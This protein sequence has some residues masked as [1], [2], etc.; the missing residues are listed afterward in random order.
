MYQTIRTEAALI[1]LI[2]QIFECKIQIP[3]KQKIKSIQLASS[4]SQDSQTKNKA[5]TR[6][7]AQFVEEAEN[8]W[9]QIAST[10]CGSLWKDIGRTDKGTRY[11]ADSDTYVSQKSNKHARIGH[12]AGKKSLRSTF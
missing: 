10:R 3:C 5:N 4:N 11:K 12:V 2:E 7:S 1:I 8:R 6:Q 9:A